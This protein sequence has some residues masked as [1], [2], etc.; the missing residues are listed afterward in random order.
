[1]NPLNEGNPSE[2]TGLA[3]EVQRGFDE[4]GKL[5]DRLKRY[6]FARERALIN[7]TQITKKISELD[8][9]SSKRAHYEKIT[10]RISVC[11]DYIGFKHYYT[12]GKVRLT[13][14]NFCKAH[15]LCP[16]CAIRRGSKFLE[17][18]LQRY[19]IIKAENPALKLSML[20]LTVKNGDDLGERFRHLKRS[21]KKML[22]RRRKAL[23]GARGWHSEFAKIAGLV[24]SIEITK[25]GGQGEIK[26]T[27]WHPH[28][29][30]MVLHD[31]RFDYVALQDE[32]LKITGD[33]HVLNVTPAKHPNDPAQDFLEVFKYALKFADLTPDQNLEAY[34]VMR[35]KHL[36]FS[37]GHFWGVK[38]PESMLDVELD[39]LP[40]IELFYQYIVGSGYNLD[41][42]FD[43][44]NLESGQKRDKGGQFVTG[45]KPKCSKA[46]YFDRFEVPEDITKSLKEDLIEIGCT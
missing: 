14:A 7:I 45:Y 41:R 15:L 30:I 11:G 24:G 35:G 21:L 42:T 36:L 33:S 44:E 6:A 31:E 9:R 3:A 38:L 46:S 10:S 16:L 4:S 12:V 26:E 29:H 20:T 28:A 27:G 23:A 37:A 32:W 2:L 18:Y 25:D 13:G 43:S 40:Y 5:P 39:E 22:E 8:E 19:E 34:D 17:S 1:M